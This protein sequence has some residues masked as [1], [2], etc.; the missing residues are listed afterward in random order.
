MRRPVIGRK[1][2]QVGIELV[3]QKMKLAAEPLPT[4]VLRG[5]A[6]D[7]A[8]RVGVFDLLLI[9]VEIDQ[10]SIAGKRFFEASGAAMQF[11]RHPPRPSL[12][13]A[14]GQQ[15]K[16]GFRLG[17]GFGQIAP[18]ERQFGELGG[19]RARFGRFLCARRGFR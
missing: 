18:F 12:A 19:D 17:V 14:G 11:G 10:R 16:R 7:R 9:V 4:G 5:A 1:L 13:S 6:P 3:D 2:E 8:Q 15:A